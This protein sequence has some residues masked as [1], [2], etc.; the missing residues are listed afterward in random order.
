MMMTLTRLLLNGLFPASFWIFFTF[1]WYIMF[2]SIM[3]IWKKEWMGMTLLCETVIGKAQ[4][5]ARIECP[6]LKIISSS[7]WHSNPVHWDRKSL[8]Y[9]CATSAATNWLST[10]WTFDSVGL[11]FV[12]AWLSF[13]FNLTSATT[14]VGSNSKWNGSIKLSK[15]INGSLEWSKRPSDLGEPT[16]DIT[17]CC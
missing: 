17:D 13:V 8:F 6:I 10:K 1:S 2:T 16:R 14:P 15:R 5:Q 7:T 12:Q 4:C 9:R 11:C 3:A